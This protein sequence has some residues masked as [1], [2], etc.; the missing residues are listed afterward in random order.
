M[1]TLIL[2]YESAPLVRKIRVGS[3]PDSVKLTVVKYSACNNC[4]IAKAVKAANVTNRYLGHVTPG[5]IALSKPNIESRSTTDFPAF[6]TGDSLGM[7]MVEGLAYVDRLEI[8][9]VT[10]SSQFCPGVF[11]TTDPIELIDDNGLFGAS[12]GDLWSLG[13]L[14]GKEISYRPDQNQYG[15]GCAQEGM[16]MDQNMYIAEEGVSETKI[17][18]TAGYKPSGDYY[19][20]SNIFI[21]DLRILGSPVHTTGVKDI[22]LNADNECRFYMLGNTGMLQIEV[23]EPVKA[24]VIYD[25]NGKA[26]KV[27]H[28]IHD[29]LVNLSSLRPGM[30]VVH[31]YG[32]SGKMYTGS[33][34]KAY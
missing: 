2:N 32:R 12:F 30:Y 26:I 9:Y 5:M 20:Y 23:D 25:M 34:G 6:M 14:S 31:T 11:Y 13:Q 29:N 19:V 27:V 22:L 21:H 8:G 17:L 16:I 18:I 33:F 1:T 24:L 10:S 7:L 4:L 15:W 28:D 3:T